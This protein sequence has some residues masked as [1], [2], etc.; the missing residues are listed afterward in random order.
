MKDWKVMEEMEVRESKIGKTGAT[1]TTRSQLNSLG[2][3]LLLGK[4]ENGE[5]ESTPREHHRCRIICFLWSSVS[6]RARR[7][8]NPQE[9]SNLP[10]GTPDEEE[11]EEDEF[12]TIKR[13]SVCLSGETSRKELFAFDGLNKSKQTPQETAMTSFLGL[14][15]C[16]EGERKRDVEEERE[17]D[18]DFGSFYDH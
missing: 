15:G 5:R 10:A 6:A 4:K 12:E 7:E 18:E 1:I 2:Q 3:T 16:L 14:W 11:E 9:N 13:A 17:E 8:E